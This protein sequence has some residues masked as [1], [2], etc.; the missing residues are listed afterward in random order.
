[1]NWSPTDE[2]WLATLWEHGQSITAI[3]R[4]MGG[5]YSRN[6]VVGKARRMGLPERE[7]PIKP[8]RFVACKT[9]GN[10]FRAHG[11][12]WVNCE[13]HRGR[14]R[15]MTQEV[16]ERMI[17]LRRKSLTQCEIAK[18]VGCHQTTVSERLLQAGISGFLPKGAV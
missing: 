5:K 3:S 15:F 8:A 16:V 10:R 14:R 9:C 4:A 18:L 7:S 12:Q 1:M 6:A 11:N 2:L 13:K 17:E